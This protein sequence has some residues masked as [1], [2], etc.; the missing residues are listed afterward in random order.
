MLF[1]SIAAGMLSMGMALG[2]M[3][4]P[5]QP[6]YHAGAAHVVKAQSMTPADTQ[7]LQSALVDYDAGNLAR[8]QPVLLELASRYPRQMQVQA[9][10]G[11]TLAELGKIAEATPYLLQA[12]TLAPDNAEVALNL[13]VA[14][15]KA[16]QAV[17]AVPLLQAA[18]QQKPGSAELRVTLAQAQMQANQPEAAVQSYAKA[19]ALLRASGSTA[20]AELR[21]DWAAALLNANKAPQAA[22]VLQEVPA[23]ENSAPVQELLAEVEE[24]SGH[25]EAA[26]RHFK[27]AAE[28]DPSEPNLYAYGSELMQHW[29]F[30]A[31]IEILS[32]ASHKYPESERLQMGLG[33]AYY[34]NS[35]YDKAVPVFET[36]LAKQPDS[37]AAADLLGRSC[38]AISGGQQAGCAT[39][40]QFAQMHPAN[41]PASLYAAIAILHQPAEQ[42]DSGA[43]ESLLRNA[44][45]VDPKLAEAW[46]QLAVLQQTRNEW[47]AS[48]ASLDRA[49]GVR[50]A[51]PEAHYRLARA[52]SH[53]GKRDE[54]QQQIA[55]QQKYAAETKAAE[56]KRMQEVMTFL[57]TAN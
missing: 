9:A 52:Y 55:L 11:M 21:Q 40:R 1:R 37:A 18:V 2:G 16:N 4:L 48:A 3:G 10:A 42:Q 7:R 43:V 53:L 54:A 49:L 17:K 27:R 35:A 56:N 34:G 14:Y 46:Y 47:Q 28:L 13:A 39:L 20:N 44:L 19:D 36:L 32:F 24:K 12:H 23:A 26:V 5:A 41:A 15:L 57:T 6:R 25:Y 30:P 29:T 33:I 31:A 38:S 50:P 8:A 45:R 51:Y 22:A